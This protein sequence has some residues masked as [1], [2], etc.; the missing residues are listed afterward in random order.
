MNGYGRACSART[1][2]ADICCA[3]LDYK[4]VRASSETRSGVPGQTVRR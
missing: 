3:G 1:G 2:K 4:P